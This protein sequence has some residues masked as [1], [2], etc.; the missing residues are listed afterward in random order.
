MNIRELPAYAYFPNVAS[1]FQVGITYVADTEL[2]NKCLNWDGSRSYT[3][4]DPTASVIAITDNLF[5]DTVL[6]R[7]IKYYVTNEPSTSGLAPAALNA[8]NHCRQIYNRL[9]NEVNVIPNV[10]N[11]ANDN[12][13]SSSI[14]T[15]N[16]YTLEGS[17]V[18]QNLF[19]A[20]MQE[21][22]PY[23]EYKQQ[24][25]RSITGIY[26]FT[27]HAE[28][29]ITYK[30]SDPQNLEYAEC[31]IHIPVL[32]GEEMLFNSDGTVNTDLPNQNPL[33]TIIARYKTDPIKG[34][35][36]YRL[37]VGISD[38]QHHASYALQSFKT[39]L[40][41]YN[42]R[43]SGS[44]DHDSDNPYAKNGISDIGGG[45]GTLVPGGLDS[46]DPADIPNLP[47]V[48]ACDI[49]FMTMYNPTAQQLRSLSDF[50][51]SGV[52]DL[53][54]YKKL[55][56]DPMQSII[57]LAIVPVQPST[58]SS[59]N[60]MFGTIDS[61]VSMTTLSS[62]Y[63]QLDCG[64][65]KLEKF[66]G[67]FLDSD[68]YTKI[69][70]YLP[71]VG[72]RQLS[73][74]DLMGG[75]IQVVYNIDVLTGA[76]GCFIKHSTRGVLYSYNGSCITNVP[77]TAS[78]FSGAIQNAVSAVISGIGT[79]AGMATGAAPLTAMGVTG[80][81]NS[82]A[83]T[84]MNSKPSIQRSGN[85]GGSAG[86]MSIQKPYVII[87]RPAYSVPSEVEKYVG[88]TSNITATLGN[89]KGFTMCEYIHMQ[90]CWGTEN[91]LKEIEAL[92]K[93]GVVL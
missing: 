9:Y 83:N 89:C 16:N 47:T 30:P 54:T 24:G 91:E 10:I 71:Y 52:F 38:D 55:F 79:V 81:L 73:A 36:L 5:M 14:Y 46:I 35:Y 19:Y 42:D 67:S 57:G 44:T 4:D 1:N 58:G 59:K 88:Q 69:S 33:I 13:M 64:S 48:S 75:S 74:D 8:Y 29:G 43:G 66:V 56:S 63:V 7:A 76:C 78:N 18:G 23:Y 12:S 34:L 68:P 17:S 25:G 27:P 37:Q 70:I 26:A 15:L 28:I 50:M 85:L 65:V 32:P 20:F 11:V 40:A 90:G 51:W 45:D 41:N 22:P 77:L 6:S 39:V 3:Y 87:E 93:E 82:A 21:V 60:V 61:G 49:G 84:A 2:Y 80:L 72:I 62:Q 31:W 86:I 53:D 92:L